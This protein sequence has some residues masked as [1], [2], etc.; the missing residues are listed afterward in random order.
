MENKSYY[1]EK[2]YQKF[3]RKVSAGLLAVVIYASYSR[4]SRWARGEDPGRPGDRHEGN[5]A[6]PR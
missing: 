3:V 4:G 1:P 5:Y 6:Q 2:S